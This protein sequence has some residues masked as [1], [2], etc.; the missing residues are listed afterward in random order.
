MRR[1]WWNTPALGLFVVAAAAY[2]WLGAAVSHVPPAGIDAAARTLTGEAPALA[3]ILTASCLW[4]VLVAFGLAG[5][6]VAWRLPAWRDR[7]AFSIVTT[8]VTW[9][10]SNALKDV[11]RRPRPEYWIVHHE[12]SF[13]YASGHAMFA[14]VVY[15]LWAYF[16]WRSALPDAVRA[17]LAPL[18]ALWGCGVIWSRLALGAHY[19]TDLVGGV[20]LAVAMLSLAT[21]V[22]RALGRER[23][24]AAAQDAGAFS[25][26]G[27]RRA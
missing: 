26:S 15:G 2:A 4:P 1:A 23:A 9:Q 7:I 19:P 6:V 27:G 17:M 13:S 8:L 12:T 24:V 5:S 3:W 25:R 14:V 21:V 20:L 22:A 10:L 16:V 18:L 11:F